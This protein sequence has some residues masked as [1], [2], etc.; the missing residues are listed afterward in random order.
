MRQKRRISLVR[1]VEIRKMN[2]LKLSLSI[3]FIFYSSLV[4][5]ADSG[6]TIHQATSS[7]SGA[8]FE[9][10]QSTLAARWTFRLDRFTG[11]VW[12]LVRTSDD[13]NAWQEMEVSGLTPNKGSTRAKF[14]IF[15][16]GMAA[17]YTFLLDTDSGKTWVVV[18]GSYKDQDG[19]EVEYNS[20]QPFASQ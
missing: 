8:R 10:I 13:E 11:R 19:N 15:S 17:R 18:T 9:I 3:V 7:P 4:F 16:S 14:Q 2:K 5:G 12:Q 1:P 20:W 6:V